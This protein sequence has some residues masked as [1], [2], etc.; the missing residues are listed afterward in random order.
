MILPDGIGEYNVAQKPPV[1]PGSGI[2]RAP[3]NAKL[4]SGWCLR[5][6]STR[7][8]TSGGLQ[9]TASSS[10]IK[11]RK[12]CKWISKRRGCTFLLLSVTIEEQEDAYLLKIVEGYCTPP[13]SSNG[14]SGSVSRMNI[15]T[16]S[17]YP[18]PRRATS[19]PEEMRPQLIMA[20]DEKIFVEEI[21]GGNVVL[22]E[23]VIKTVLGI[24]PCFRASST[25]FMNWRT[26]SRH[27]RK[28]S[29][30]L[31][32]ISKTNRKHAED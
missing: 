6:S 4:Y 2:V 27:S 29:R 11:L 15:S 10:S 1:V 3:R 22:K 18:P 16:V 24:F 31:S 17:S 28:S 32:R 30:Q 20:N 8:N 7:G 23:K 14:L 5:P 25:L 21:E 9:S 13:N 26:K 12:G 19:Y